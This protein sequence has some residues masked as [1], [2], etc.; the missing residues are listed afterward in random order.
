M[1][2]LKRVS[3]LILVSA[4]VFACSQDKNRLEPKKTIIAGVI[5]NF[6]DEVVLIN[7]CDY[8]S[9]ERR[10]APNLTESNGYFQTEH[11]YLFAQNITIRFANNFINLFIHQGD[12]VFVTIDSNEIQH[13]YDNAVTF[14]GD[15]SELNKELFLWYNYF[16]SLLNQ[17]I[18]QFDDNTLPEEFLAS[19]KRDF[20]KAQDTINAYSKR[21]GMSDFMK[22][23]AYADYKF[24]I[25]NYLMD[26][27]N[28]EVNRW[29]IFTN[30]IFD[31]FDENNFQTMYFPYHLGVCM[32]ALIQSEVKISRLASE[33]KYIPVVRLT[34]EKLFEKAPKGVV[35]D[36][37]LFE[38]LKKIVNEMPELCDSMPNIKTIF[39]QNYFNT[40]LERLAEQN[41]RIKQATELSEAE[42]QLDGILYL[43][44]DKIEE[45]PNVA[46]LNYLSEK[47]KDKVLYVDVWA[48]WCGPC[49]EEFKFTPNLHKHFKDKD[50]VFVNLCLSSN[51]DSWKPSILK[52]NVNGENY[53]LDDKASQI[54]M[55]N[56]NLEGFPSYLII[57]KNRKIHYPAPRPSDLESAIQKIE[58]CLQ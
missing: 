50:V 34:I 14:S 10:F 55:G 30:P 42:R 2:N 53:F 37:M 20:D 58:S 27:R 24:V 41:K 5:N 43:A 44:N 18:P 23:W 19:V 16:S 15:N 11:E 47:H 12:S 36:V 56:N 26:Y 31:V 25:A 6:S 48:T 1:N 3:C 51:I 49:I 40:E 45:L 29:D 32:N 35:R 4:F 9:D 8:L 46:L 28:P 13:N 33:K 7:Y 39:S 22:K 21:T 38:F 52:N 54:F 57:D 17:N